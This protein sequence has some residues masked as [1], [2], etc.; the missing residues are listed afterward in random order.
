[1]LRCVCFDLGGVL[2]KI[3]RTW[4]HAASVHG[5]SIALDA[6][7]PIH[8]WELD[9]FNRFQRGEWDEPTYF[10]RLAARLNVS[11]EEAERVHNGVLE[12]PYVGTLE[13]I[14]DL[15]TQGLV[16]ACLSNT[17][18]SHWVEMLETGRFPNVERLGV[19]VASH[20][21]RLEKPSPEIYK[22]FEEQSGFSG[23]EICFFDDLEANVLAAREAGWISHVIDPHG[24]PAIEMRELLSCL[25][26][27]QR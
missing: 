20:L 23:Q 26:A 25:D 24:D 27:A 4:Q 15:E 1:M 22:A 17:N 21:A 13:L 7:P 11:E 9:E 12:A 3:C 8:I 16:T 5:I 10:T 6:E 19:K 18:H 2:V 14:E